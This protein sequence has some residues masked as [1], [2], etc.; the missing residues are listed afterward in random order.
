V[1]RGY[2][3]DLT[4]RGETLKKLAFLGGAAGLCAA[5]LLATPITPS[6]AADHLD[7]PGVAANPM[8]DINDVYAWMADGKL[9]LAMTVS[10]AD[11]PARAFGPSVQYVFHV[12]SKTGIGV[13][14]AGTGVETRVICTFK[15]NADATCWVV[16]P[17]GGGT[18]TVKDYVTGDP[19]NP[20]G[21][22]SASGKVRFFAGQRSDPF[23]FNL[24][25]FRDA[26]AAVKGR[27][28]TAPPVMLD[29]AGCP[30]NLTDPEVGVVRG[31]L[32][33]TPAV[34][35]PPCPTGV[36]DCFLGFNVKVVLVQVD[37]SLVNASA[38]FAVGVWASTHQGS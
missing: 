20:A 19:S 31:L 13:G 17:A 4:Q 37:K 26:V 16:D 32:S 14:V 15:S 29:V 36:K 7:A 23:F 33:E 30:S 25:G 38:N 24:Q 3:K 2:S 22:T 1:R 27:I 34:V 35:Q 12:H 11:M 5:A 8:A 18:G 28:G 9:V 21:I 10:P 6:L